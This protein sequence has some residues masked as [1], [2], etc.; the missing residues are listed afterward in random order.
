MTTGWYRLYVQDD[1]GQIGNGWRLIHATIGRKWAHLCDP[2]GC[3]TARVPRIKFS[4]MSPQPVGS[5]NLKRLRKYVRTWGRVT[6]V[7]API[8]ALLG[9]K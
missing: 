2:H 5:V 1:C 7:P 3:N 4:A 6:Y 8:K 9:V